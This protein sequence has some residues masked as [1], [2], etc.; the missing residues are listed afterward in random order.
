V[1]KLIDEEGVD[2]TRPGDEARF[3]KARSG[4]HLMTPFQCDL[5]HFRNMMGRNPVLTLWSD[6]EILEYVRRASLDAFWSREV[7]TVAKNLSAARKMERKVAD[8]LGLPSITPPMGPF[9]LK[10]EGGMATA[11]AVLDRSLEPGKHDVY[12]QWETFRK[13]R[14]AAT[15]IIQAGSG[16]LTNSVGA[17]ERDRVW[18]SSAATQSFWFSRFMSGVH[19]R[20]GEIRKPD[21]AFTIEE[22][23]AIGKVLEREWKQAITIGAQKTI[24]EMGVIFIVGM[25]TAIRGEELLL[26]DLVGTKKSL[27]NLSE[28]D[29]GH[30]WLKI[31]GRTKGNQ[32]SGAEFNVPCV[33]V[34]EGTGLRP[35]KWIRRLVRV[36]EAKGYRNGP[37]LRRK[38]IPPKLMEFEND[39]FK[40]IEKVQAVSGLIAEEVCVRDEYGLDR[41]T[42]RAGTIHAKNMRVPDDVV[43][44]NNR[45]RREAVNGTGGGSRLDLIEVYTTLEALLPTALRFSRAF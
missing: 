1:K 23:H 5:C 10:D 42:R 33:G 45:W 6:R 39:F 40:V 15:N 38:L 41:S 37:L 30:F 26:V 20:V 4:D 22:I 25:C 34:T 31:L 43:N 13:V 14:S 11:I 32:L 21:R 35:G 2:Q 27:K 19:K 24:A 7:S 3:M 12:V 16:G 28:N 29:E 18:I 44:A 36:L 17:Y 8:R 9:P